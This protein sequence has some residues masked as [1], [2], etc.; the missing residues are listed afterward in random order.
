MEMKKDKN[1]NL[2][3][4]N[5]DSKILID[6]KSYDMKDGS[7]SF[8]SL[9]DNYLEKTDD[10][11]QKLNQLCSTGHNICSNREW[12]LILIDCDNVGM[13][14]HNKTISVIQAQN[15]IHLLNVNIRKHVNS[16][17]I[18]NDSVFGYHLGSDLFGIFVY[19]NSSTMN[20]SIEIVESLLNVMRNKE[21]SSLTISV[22]I[23]FRMLKLKNNKNNK[24]NNNITTETIKKEWVSR[25]YANLLRAKENG[26]NCFFKIQNDIDMTK[27]DKKLRLLTAKVDQLYDQ[28]LLNKCENLIDIILN[29]YTQDEIIKQTITSQNNEC[30]SSIYFIQAWIIFYHKTHIGNLIYRRYKARE[31]INLSMKTFILGNMTVECY[32]YHKQLQLEIES[33]I[34]PVITS[35][36]QKISQ[37][38]E[39]RLNDPNNQITKKYDLTLLTRTQC[40]DPNIVKHVIKGS[41]LYYSKNAFEHLHVNDKSSLIV[42][43]FAID[44]AELG[45]ETYDYARVQQL[46]ENALKRDPNCYIAKYN[47]ALFL[48]KLNK[49]DECLDFIEFVMKDVAVQNNIGFL[50]IASKNFCDSCTCRIERKLYNKQR[51]KDEKLNKAIEYGQQMSNILEKEKEWVS[52]TIQ[53]YYF[54][55]ALLYSW[56]KNFDK[57]KEEQVTALKMYEKCIK[58]DQQFGYDIINNWIRDLN[59]F[60]IELVNVVVDYWY[61]PVDNTNIYA[62]LDYVDLIETYFNQDK[63]KMKRA[64]ILRCSACAYGAV[65]KYLSKTKHT[66]SC[67][68]CTKPSKYIYRRRNHMDV[69]GLCTKLVSWD[70][71]QGGQLSL[72]TSGKNNHDHESTTQ[73]TS[74]FAAKL[75]YFFTFWQEYRNFI[76]N[77]LGLTIDMIKKMQT[78]MIKLLMHYSFR[79]EKKEHKNIIEMIK[80]SVMFTNLMDKMNHVLILQ[81]FGAMCDKIEKKI[82]LQNEQVL[83]NMSKI[84]FPYIVTN[85]QKYVCQICMFHFNCARLLT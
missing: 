51:T 3:D 83:I 27:D 43:G 77:E 46:C 24:D 40:A 64:K 6:I 80:D 58:M 85:K 41:S 30:L 8:C 35:T 82:D 42:T 63:S 25:A 74:S 68:S 4:E 26:K 60:E 49:Y 15:S 12:T 17:T 45:E 62:V 59:K 50:H 19:D 21:K 34:N 54:V 29:E 44:T 23:G 52:G 48:W 53:M 33:T 18:A 28:Y 20:K 55:G 78:I 69:S 66:F 5:S 73:F 72:S 36:R 57:N 39:K 70:M 1:G 32:Y 2:S 81:E 13:L 61:I 56:S 71:D 79:L 31:L 16:N 22:G 9:L 75:A 11:L 84:V 14:L 47:Y 67:I 7:S 37:E 65:R 38:T 76:V 10:F